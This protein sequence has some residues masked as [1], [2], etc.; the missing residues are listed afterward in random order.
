MPTVK[1]EQIPTEDEQQDTSAGVYKNNQDTFFT[2]TKRLLNPVKI[3]KYLAKNIWKPVLA[4]VLLFGLILGLVYAGSY[5][6]LLD[7]KKTLDFEN[8][9]AS[10]RQSDN[11]IVTSTLPVLEWIASSFAGA[12]E[13][14]QAQIDRQEQQIMQKEQELQEQK[15]QEE[16]KAQEAEKEKQKKE[17]EQQKAAANK[18]TTTSAKKDQTTADLQKAADERQKELIKRASKLATYYATMPP[19]NAINIMKNMDNE[20]IIIVLSRMPDETAS[21]I[22]AGF[23]PDRASIISKSILK[24][25]PTVEPTTPNKAN[26]VL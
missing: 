17:Q 15:K 26:D 2:K 24:L 8:S 10:L 18:Q 23:E 5:Y 3:I 25:R 11:F 13:I 19:Q 9:M 22:L 14:M 21:Q 1:Q 12:G 6:K 7:A 16:L 20:E 4:F